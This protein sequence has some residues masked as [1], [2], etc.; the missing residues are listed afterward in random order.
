MVARRDVYFPFYPLPPPGRGEK[1]DS[2]DFGEK[3]W[4]A[5]T[6][7]KIPQRGMGKKH[8]WKI[9][10]YKADESKIHIINENQGKFM[11]F[12]ILSNVL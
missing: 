5:M 3:T 2:K 6:A 4:L 7:W 9:N 8:E 1:H 12:T 11:H 10:Y